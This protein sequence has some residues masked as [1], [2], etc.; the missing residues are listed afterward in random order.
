MS[1]QDAFITIA[2][3]SDAVEGVP[4]FTNRKK[5]PA[6]MIQFQ[7]LTEQPYTLDHEE[8]VFEVYV[9]QK[10][11]P[12]AELEQNRDRL[13]HEFHQK[14]HA[15]LRA[16]ALTKKFGWGAH[17]NQKGKIALYSVNSAEYQQFVADEEIKKFPAMKK[18]R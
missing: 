11:I 5:I 4:P 12:A 1:Y 6:H 17:Y 7:L 13:W 18:K 3:D 9:R 2:P 16:S 14:G 8:L 15:C 10:E